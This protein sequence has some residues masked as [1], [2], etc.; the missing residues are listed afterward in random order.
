MLGVEL[1]ES[2]DCPSGWGLG[3]WLKSRF[4]PPPPPAPLVPTYDIAAEA[5]RVFET[6]PAIAELRELGSKLHLVSGDSV[7]DHPSLTHLSGKRT[8]DGR[9]WD[10]VSAVCVGLDVYIAVFSP[11]YTTS[12]DILR[13]D[14][15][16]ESGHALNFGL[17]QAHAELIG[18]PLL[19]SSAV[20][21]TIHEQ[22]V[23]TTAY[24]ESE[25]GEAWAE[26]YRMY[27]QNEALPTNVYQ[28]IND[29]VWG[30]VSLLEA[31][32]PQ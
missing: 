17:G 18:A 24:G 5:T 28:I 3:S 11:T 15:W 6:Q 1:L 30:E 20:W 27:C 13:E 23:W 8:F 12:A 2:R 29:A 4:A 21:L 14:V 7:T 10:S 32:P 31:S 25:S 16:H 19:S 26:S 22:Q 9:L